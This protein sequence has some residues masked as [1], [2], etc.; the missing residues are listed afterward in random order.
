MS[1]DLPMVHV[2]GEAAWTAVD[3]QGVVPALGGLIEGTGMWRT[4]TLACMD[5]T[6]RFLTGAWDPPGPEGE[7]GPGIAGEGSWT[8]FIG[9]IGAVALRA[10]VASTRP[11]RRE[12]QLAL[13]EM[14]AES[15]FADPD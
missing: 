11:E 6:G 4:G 15:P 7:D 12:R 2:T 9:R 3:D 13:L 10:A 14:W 8:R 5:R 1:D